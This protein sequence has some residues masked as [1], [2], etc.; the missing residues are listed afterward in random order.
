MKIGDHHGLSLSSIGCIE[1]S[2]TEAAATEMWRARSLILE[3][4][5]LVELSRY[6]RRSLTSSRRYQI[7]VKIHSTTTKKILNLSND[8]STLNVDCPSSIDFE[9]TDTLLLCTPPHQPPLLPQNTSL[10]V[11]TNDDEFYAQHNAHCEVCSHP[12]K[13]LCC[14]TCTLVFHVHCARPLLK[15]NLPDDWR[16]AYCLAECGKRLLCLVGSL[17]CCLFYHFCHILPFLDGAE[18]S[19]NLNGTI[20]PIHYI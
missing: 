8:M 19:C 4:G 9:K 17:S 7:M 2:A 11:I 1:M 15:K 18:R 6:Q 12:C 10:L 13:V 5:R 14:S 16:C 3:T 20:L